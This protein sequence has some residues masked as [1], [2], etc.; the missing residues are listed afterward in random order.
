M[1]NGW[2]LTWLLAPL[3]SP[4]GIALEAGSLY[5]YLLE[6]D[7]LRERDRTDPIENLQGRT[8]SSSGNGRRAS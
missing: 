1:D 2:L 5:W 4:G 6:D 7:A 3:L 8:Q